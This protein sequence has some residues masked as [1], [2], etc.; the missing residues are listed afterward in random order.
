MYRRAL[1]P[2][3][4]Q[5]VGRRTLAYGGFEFEVW[6]IPGGHVARMQIGK[7]CAS[8]LVTDQQTGLPVEGAVT[9]F[10]C[11]GEHEF[12]YQFEPSGI[13]YMAS[14]QTESLPENLYRATF[15]ETVD[16]AIE[17]E[18]LIH[19]W[20]DADGGACLSVLDVQRYGR[21]MNLQSYH[22]IASGGVVV[23]TQSL[24]RFR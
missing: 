21:E 7:A 4:F 15:R 8:E 6:L 16:L 19:R 14:A 24:F 23:R 2:E 20:T 12:E 5:L 17:T 1:H 18:G 3:L 9:S 11:A 13:R 22:L 10:P